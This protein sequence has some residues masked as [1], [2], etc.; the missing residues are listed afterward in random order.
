MTSD[1]TAHNEPSQ[2]ETAHNEPSQLHPQCLQIQLLLCLALKGSRILRHL[3][4]LGDLL[5]LLLF[6]VL[7]LERLLLKIRRNKNIMLT[8]PCNSDPL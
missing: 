2:L 1:E 8:S 4:L 3:R 5:L 7:R 6:S